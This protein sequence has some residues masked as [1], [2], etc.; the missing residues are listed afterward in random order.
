MNEQEHLATKVEVEKVRSEVAY[1]EIEIQKRITETM[2]EASGVKSVASDAKSAV[3]NVKSEV[4][5]W[6]AGI[7][8]VYTAVLVGIMIGIIFAVLE[9]W[10]RP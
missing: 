3:S 6:V 5:K 2:K 1:R 9:F 8:V 10:D 7:L 4:Y